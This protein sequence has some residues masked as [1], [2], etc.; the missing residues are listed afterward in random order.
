MLLAGFVVPVRAQVA[1]NVNAGVAPI[2]RTAGDTES[3]SGRHRADLHVGAFHVVL[4]PAGSPVPQINIRV[5]LNTNETSLVTEHAA[6]S[7]NF[8]EALLLVDR[9][10]QG[11]HLLNVCSCPDPAAE[12]WEHRRA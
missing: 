3:F 7:G 8:D 9:A 6:G 11:L 1:C 10:Q 5:F 2:V 4:T 12:L